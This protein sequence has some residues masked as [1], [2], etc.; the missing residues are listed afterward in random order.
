M[1]IKRHYPDQPLPGFDLPQFTL[2][3]IRRAREQRR[4][5]TFLPPL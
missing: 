4:Q 1:P 2:D 3:V 5:G